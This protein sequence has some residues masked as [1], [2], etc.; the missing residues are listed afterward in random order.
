[1]P[2]AAR[3]DDNH[4]CP[5]ATPLKHVGGPILAPCEPTVWI[6]SRPA[7]RVDD[8]AHCNGATDTIAEGSPTVLIGNKMAAR[9]G[10]ETQ[11]G[12]V[13]VAG[14]DDVFIC[15]GGST[16]STMSKAKQRAKALA[17]DCSGR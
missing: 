8:H 12:G 1:M 4:T 14:S 9:K 16:S 17:G 2:P 15:D 13:I 6:N 5:L 7:A 10:D 3:R 11:H